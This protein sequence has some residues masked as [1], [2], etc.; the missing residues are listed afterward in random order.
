L[1]FTQ[2]EDDLGQEFKLSISHQVD[3]FTLPIPRMMH[4]SCFVRN[5][6][7]SLTLLV[8]GG[9]V[10][11]DQASCGYTDSVIGYDCRFLFQPH[12]ALKQDPL[13]KTNIKWESLNNMHNQRANFGLCQV[14]NF[15]YVFGGI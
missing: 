4:N 6:K 8:I 10:G 15:V 2:Q 14:D 11:L 7:G 9:K 12:L 13:N 1:K 3:S 5:S